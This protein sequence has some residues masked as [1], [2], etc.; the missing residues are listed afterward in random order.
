MRAEVVHF[1]RKCRWRDNLRLSHGG[2]K[3][4]VHEFLELNSLA[5]RSRFHLG[6]Q[7]SLH[8]QPHD[9]SPINFITA[10]LSGRAS[11]GS[12][13][14]V[15]IAVSGSFNPCPVSVAVIT[16]PAGIKF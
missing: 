2:A 5:T 3:S 15:L 12:N 13:P 14:A 6:E 16:L 9:H 4:A 11:S 10:A 8:L 1:L 7:F